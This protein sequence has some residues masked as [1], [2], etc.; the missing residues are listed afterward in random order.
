MLDEPLQEDA[1]FLQRC[2]FQLQA[3]GAMLM[4]ALKGRR[5]WLL[6]V[7]ASIKYRYIL[8][9]YQMSLCKTVQC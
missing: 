1:M 8:C 7:A 6:C 3:G 9:K 2:K 4:L 5:E